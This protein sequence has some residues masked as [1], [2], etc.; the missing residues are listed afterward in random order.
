MSCSS[1][2]IA[3]KDCRKGDG[4]NENY[5]RSFYGSRNPDW[6]AWLLA[7]VIQFGKPGSI[8]DLGCGL[9]LFVE[10]A[11]RWGVPAKGIDGSGAAV[12]LA[13]ER[14]PMLDLQQGNL[15]HP[16]PF[17]DQSFDNI[18]MHQVIPS[19]PRAVLTDLLL[20]CHRLLR[21][22]G[23]LFLLSASKCNLSA[24]ERDPSQRYRLHPSELRILLE[25]AGFLVFR[26]PNSVRFFQNSRVLRKLAAELLRTPLKDW[27]A[28][29]ANAYA[30]RL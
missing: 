2:S 17:A 23:I 1:P 22:G 30:Q 14:A 9:G 7:E 18:M 24:Y 10:F 6:Y 13:L 25:S 20:Q 27:A 3:S 29:T 11:D 16:L 8:L 28:G 21:P 4:F 12:H 15:M 19:F 5:Y 26:E